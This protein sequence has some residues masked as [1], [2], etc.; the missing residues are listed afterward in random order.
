MNFKSICN[1]IAEILEKKNKEYGESFKKTYEE[2]GN[3]AICLRLEDKLNRLKNILQKSEYSESID[4]L[5]DIAGYAVLSLTVI[6][7]KNGTPE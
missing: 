5:I 3:T 2:Y 4:T 1:D 6:G 7:T